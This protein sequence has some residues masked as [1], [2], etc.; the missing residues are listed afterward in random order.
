MRR[1]LT[2]AAANTMASECLHNRILWVTEEGKPNF[3][4]GPAVKMFSSE[5]FRADSF[6]LLNLTAPE[7]LAFADEDAVIINL[8]YRHSQVTTVYGGTSEVQ[9]SQV[10]E[11][12]LNL[13]RTR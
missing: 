13:P 1:R 11:R 8:S 6:D 9:R 12:Q 4:Y 10:A 5:A 2:R 7:S 3:A